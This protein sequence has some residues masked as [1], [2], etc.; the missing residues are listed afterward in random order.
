[1]GFDDPELI[2]GDIQYLT[3]DVFRG[4]QNRRKPDLGAFAG[5]KNLSSRDYPLL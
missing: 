1:M 2:P 3:T 4:Y 5:M